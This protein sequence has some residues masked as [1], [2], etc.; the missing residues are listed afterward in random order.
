MN[1][2]T[3]LETMSS[4]CR[5]VLLG[6]ILG[7]ACLPFGNYRSRNGVRFIETHGTAQREYIEW[8]A[9]V[10]AELGAHITP[11]GCLTINTMPLFSELRPWFYTNGGKK[12][13][14]PTQHLTPYIDDVMLLTWYLDDGTISKSY[15][16]HICSTLPRDHVDSF[17]DV[18][19]EAMDLDLT[20]KTYPPRTEERKPVNRIRIPSKDQRVL[21]TR[22]AALAADLDLPGSMM[23]K[24]DRALSRQQWV[25]YLTLEE[26]SFIRDHATTMTTQEIADAIGRPFNTVYRYAQTN[27]L[28]VLSNASRPWTPEEIDIV[29]DL[30]PNPS[31]SLEAVAA[32]INRTVK[33]VRH[34]ARALRLSRPR[35]VS[36]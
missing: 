32:K 27:G 22:W 6:S 28:D 20:V 1:N 10:M 25:V 5:G 3:A 15:D 23:Y 2:E 17:V 14:L 34:R 26:T 19:N 33:S 9:S 12:N 29:K 11:S 31:V 13:A 35:A 18:V 30:Y 21:F 16:A 4:T 7:D 24:I 36:H 8:K